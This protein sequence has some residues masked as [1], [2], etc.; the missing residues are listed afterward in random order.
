[1]E[2]WGEEVF[3]LELWAEINEKSALRARTSAHPSLPSTENLREG[4]LVDGTLFD[5]LIE[6][7]SKLAG[8]AEDIMIKQVC[9]E[10][11]GD[12]KPYFSSPWE[13]DTDDSSQTIPS[14]L[15]RPLSSLSSSLKFFTT[16][17]LPADFV[18]TAYKRVVG[19]LTAHFIQRLVHHRAKGR[20]TS[21]F[22]KQF[23]SNCRLWVE[24][25]QMALVSPG[26]ELR[27]GSN[28]RIKIRRPEAAWAKLVDATTLLSVE[29]AEFPDVLQAVFEGGPDKYST[30]S[31]ALGLSGILSRAEAQDI[32][33]ARAEAPRR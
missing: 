15:L 30:L 2:A 19:T 9:Y 32:L 11:E 14:A 28:R 1:V 18:T 16:S 25:S 27:E 3:F 7:Y 24:A 21:A 8:R 4:T 26:L 13:V 22:G 23:A 17:S 6:Q 10:I 33:R 20:F 31:E 12:L 5:E 29:E